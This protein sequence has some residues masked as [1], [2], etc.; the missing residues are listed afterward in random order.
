MN[1]PHWMKKITRMQAVIGAVI[2]LILAPTTLFAAVDKARFWTWTW[3]FVAHETRDAVRFNEI[4][5]AAGAQ[6]EQVAADFKKRDLELLEIRLRA[7]K[8]E[9][10]DL[11]Q[12]KR[13]RGTNP[14]LRRD[15]KENEELIAKIKRRISFV[16]FGK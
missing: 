16:E 13:T 9:A 6:I 8:N 2:F 7:A 5:T 15:I 4:E 12:V 1:T 3:E 14:E 11:R 10:R